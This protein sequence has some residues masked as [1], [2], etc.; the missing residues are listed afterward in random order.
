MH[1]IVDLL[2][3]ITADAL[4]LNL[5][6][7]QKSRNN[8]QVLN[9]KHP[10]SN[11]VVHVRF[12]HNNLHSLGNHYDSIIYVR[13]QNCSLLETSMSGASSEAKTCDE[14]QKSAVRGKSSKDQKH[15]YQSIDICPDNSPP[16]YSSIIKQRNGK[17]VDLTV[18]D[19]DSGKSDTTYFSNPEGIASQ[20]DI[21][22]PLPPPT[23]TSSSETTRSTLTS[24]NEDLSTVTEPHE[25][26][27]EALLRNI[28]RGK[29][30]P[31]WYFT[32][33]P[34]KHVSTIPKDINGI[35]L[36]KMKVSPGEWLKATSDNQH[37]LIMTSS[38]EG[39]TG[40]IRIG[41]CMG[42]YVY[43]NPQC[44]FVRTSQNQA[45]NKVSWHILR[46]QRGVHICTICD[47][48][49]R[50]AVAKNLLSMT[51]IYKKLLSTISVTTNAGQKLTQGHDHGIYGRKYRKENY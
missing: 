9:F 46:G 48:I 38:C 30:F 10:L 15:Q 45:P 14:I 31:R 13:P 20:E 29:P 42:S 16:T 6:I 24:S 2:M 17:I 1:D 47:H 49:E 11:R 34:V 19:S 18:D 25:S 12:T 22:F 35:A 39:F 26:E 5:F 44:P 21:F 50:V 4:R 3:Q 41:T 7:Y 28:S 33:I 36:Y 51:H 43:N 8:I 23:F 37:F 40:K 27:M 32:N